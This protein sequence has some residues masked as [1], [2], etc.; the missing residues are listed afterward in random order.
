M[1]F[2]LYLQQR[3]LITA[4][5]FIRALKLQQR[6]RQ[7]LGLIAVEEGLLTPPDL[8][9]I[10]QRQTDLTNDRLGDVAIELGILNRR[11][12]A[13][14]LLMQLD[15]ELPFGECLVRLGILTRDEVNL[16]MNDYRQ[17]REQAALPKVQRVANARSES[18]VGTAE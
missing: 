17:E 7:P 3:G 4:E 16:Y 13:M 6:E 14:L 12:V 11:D 5:Q 8:L 2:G 1:Q 9:R 15:R 10:L 18:P